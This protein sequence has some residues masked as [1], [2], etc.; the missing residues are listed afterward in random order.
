LQDK[1]IEEPFF[2]EDDGELTHGEISQR[3][4]VIKRFREL[5]LEQRNRFRTYLDA[6]EKQKDVIESGSTD[7][8]VAQVDLEER[9]ISDIFSLQKVI[10][11]LETMYRASSPGDE[12]EVPVLKSSLD[13][14]KMEALKRSERNKAILSRRMEQL[15][16]EIKKLRSNPYT[17]AKKS[18]F[19]AQEDPT[20]IDIEG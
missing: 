3:V 7:E 6:L 4:A 8:L 5:L 12:E 15:R 20:I 1:P 2:T 14:L 16:M 10:D 17:S 19:L 11:P 9:I 18:R 13:E